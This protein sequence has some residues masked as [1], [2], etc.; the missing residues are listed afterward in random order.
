MG[1][2]E[3]ISAVLER[4]LFPLPRK[5]LEVD[6]T[7][8]GDG[9]FYFHDAG[10]YLKGILVGTQKRQ[11]LHYEFKTYLMKVWQA[12]QDGQ[13]LI[14]K[15]NQVVEFPANMK[16][17]RI[18]EDNQL[19]GAVIRVVYKG[20]RGRYKLYDV[21]KDTGTFY[22][23]EEKKYGKSSR[24]NRKSR[25]PAFAGAGAKQNDQT[26]GDDRPAS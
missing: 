15:G 18:I 6:D 23:S 7:S 5:L 13:P 17:R 10:D 8:V 9:L 4:Q 21:F 11:S 26:A 22:E 20:K 24:K 1:D 12:R 19:M 2:P 16:M 14:V 3:K 25:K